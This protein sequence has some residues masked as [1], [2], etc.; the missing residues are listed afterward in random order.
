[1]SSGIDSPPLIGTGQDTTAEMEVLKLLLKIRDD[2]TSK[3]TDLLDLH[4]NIKDALGMSAVDM[5]SPIIR[6]EFGPEV[7]SDTEVW[8]LYLRKNLAAEKGARADGIL[9]SVAAI[10]DRKSARGRSPLGELGE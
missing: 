9:K 4:T 3:A 8:R 10:I 7:W 5:A 6:D 2:P 1:M